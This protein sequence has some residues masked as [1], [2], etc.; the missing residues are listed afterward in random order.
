MKKRWQTY[1]FIVLVFLVSC[2]RMPQNVSQVPDYPNIYPDYID[3]NIVIT[4]YSIHYTKL[5]DTEMYRAE[6]GYPIGYFWGYKTAGIFQ[7][8]V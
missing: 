1:G 5:Y 2:N 7:N 6:V 3:V 8:L 4:S